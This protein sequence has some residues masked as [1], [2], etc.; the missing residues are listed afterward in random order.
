MSIQ[1]FARDELTRA[2]LFD[3]DSDYDGMMG[4]AVMKM[5]DQFAGEG[6]SGFSAGMALSLFEKLARWEPLT[7]LTGSDDEWCEVGDGLLQNRRCPRVFKDKN[8]AYDIEGKVFREP[9]GARF[10]S[11]DSRV[12]VTFPYVPKTEVVD[13]PA[14]EERP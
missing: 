5:I 10:S 14:A 11:Y 2:G 12:P 9:S 6:H 1:T 13:V 8:G 3:K 4:D 7:P